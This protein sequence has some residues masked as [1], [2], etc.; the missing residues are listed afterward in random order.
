MLFCNLDGGA[1]D[2]AGKVPTEPLVSGSGCLP[3]RTR[4]V[5]IQNYVQLR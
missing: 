1:G 3:G 4:G 5:F 2:I